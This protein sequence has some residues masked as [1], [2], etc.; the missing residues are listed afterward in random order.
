MSA[1][2][3]WFYHLE[4]QP[5]QAALPLLLEKTL[6]RGWRACLRFSTPERLDTI[7]SALWTYREESFLPH[8]T[9]RDGHAAWQ[10]ILLTLDSANPN[11]AQVLF[12]LET[13]TET[14]PGRF[15]RI[16]RLFDGLDEEARALARTEWREA[17][18]AGF[19]VSYWKQDAKGA[20]KKSA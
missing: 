12:L 4:S 15:V 13:A 16:M 7:D 14:E 17:K 5:L 1:P 3:Y 10:P 18:A 9:A 11:E 2:E 20:W 6:S 8:G 19:P